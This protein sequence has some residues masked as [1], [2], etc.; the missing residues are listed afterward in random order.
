[1]KLLIVDEHE[2]VRKG[3]VALLEK[4]EVITD[5]QEAGELEE[6]LKLVTIQEPPDLVL[7]DVHL[8]DQNSLDLIE[9][10]KDRQ[11][12]TKFVVLTASSRK[13]DFIRAKELGVAGYLLKD[14]NVED[15]IYAIK[16]INRGKKIYDSQIM[17]EEPFSERSNLLASLTE[18]ETEI[19][20]EIGRGL[21]NKQIAEKLY[22]TE[23]TVK[24]HIT[25][26]L[27]KL[28]VKRRTEVAL[29]AT[30]IWRRKGELDK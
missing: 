2:I 16:A 24:K 25:G 7:I 5:I 17:I 30:K 14:S 29:Y 20:L 23:N 28:G 1:M 26:L 15:I 3:L 21:T 9:M 27:S 12:D 11:I 8:G 13:G 4:E 18:R 6:A 10:C 22:I 19:F